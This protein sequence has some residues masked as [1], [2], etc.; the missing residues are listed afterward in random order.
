MPVPFLQQQ[1]GKLHGQMITCS[2]HG[3]PGRGIALVAVPGAALSVLTADK[4]LHHM[5]PYWAVCIQ[6]A[7]MGASGSCQEAL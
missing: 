2:S 7:C 6:H 1:I 3:H 5:V 4:Q